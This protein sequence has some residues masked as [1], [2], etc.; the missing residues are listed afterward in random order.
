MIY[1]QTP[2]RHIPETLARRRLLLFTELSYRAHLAVQQQRGARGTRGTHTTGYFPAINKNEI[3]SFAEK[4][5]PL[6]TIIL[7]ELSLFLVNTLFFLICG[8]LSLWGI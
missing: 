7:S 3:M 1:L 5:V 2:S 8:Y 4:M 6:E